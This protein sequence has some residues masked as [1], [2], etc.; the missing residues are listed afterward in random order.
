[1]PAS[2]TSR[3]S[4]VSACA[5]V[6]PGTSG[7]AAIAAAVARRCGGYGTGAMSATIRRVTAS[8]CI[9]AACIAALPPI[10]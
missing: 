7:S 9:S 10:E 3:A 6:I 5:R 1:M 2:G 8:G 4:A